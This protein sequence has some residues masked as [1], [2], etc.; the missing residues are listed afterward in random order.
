MNRIVLFLSVALLSSCNVNREKVDLKVNRFEK[1]LFEINNDNVEKL[2]SKL[3]ADF[4]TFNEVL[5]TQ[6]MQKGNLTDTQYYHE[7]LAF[8][9]H[10]DMR[11]A[12][13]SVALLFAD[14]SEIEEELEFAFGQFSV[15]FPSYPIPEITTLLMI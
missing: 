10:N 6:I 3:E 4:G 12:Y 13:D 15:D 14:F 8:T 7:L 2:A 5:A 1:T 11:E 9:Q